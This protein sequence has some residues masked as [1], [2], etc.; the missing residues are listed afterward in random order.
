M[1]IFVGMENPLSIEAV[2]LKQLREQL[3]HTQGSF[4][5]L[6]GIGT[7]TYDIE[8]GKVRLS[9]KAVAELVKRFNVNPLWLFGE[10]ENQ[11]LAINEL[12]VIPKV[13]TLSPNGD[14]NIVMVNQKASAGYAQNIGDVDWY[15]T[16]PVMD[17]PLPELRNATYRAF[18]VKGDSMEP[19]LQSG[20]WVL[21]KAVEKMEDL[22]TEQVY[23]FSLTDSLLIK[24]LER[25]TQN[26]LVLHSLNP[27]YSNL[28]VNVSD[29]LEVW[30]VTHTFAKLDTQST[31]LKTALLQ[32]NQ[33]LREIKG[34]L[35]RK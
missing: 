20:M 29:L 22:K 14:E 7:T 5:E 35:G 18:Q 15:E 23:V 11:Y 1:F 24:Q 2:R 12:S 3:N 6:L 8:R 27:E 26:H 17:L 21:A 31:N 19:V 9:G 16:L 13:V 10:A 30:Q 25:S 28:E 33:D 34:Y 4:A 32:I